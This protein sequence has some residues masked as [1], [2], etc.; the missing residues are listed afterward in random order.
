MKKEIIQGT[1]KTIPPRLLEVLLNEHRVITVGAVLCVGVKSAL[2][3]DTTRRIVKTKGGGRPD[4]LERAMTRRD[5][6]M[7]Q[8]RGRKERSCSGRAHSAL[9]IY[10]N[11]QSVCMCASG[12]R[13]MFF[14]RSLS[15]SLVLISHFFGSIYI[16]PRSDERRLMMM[17]ML[18]G[19]LL[20]SN[21]QK[22]ARV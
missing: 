14:R 17:M 12:G 13:R 5:C 2:E 8:R 20:P 18:I 7:E 9:Y 11:A 19:C 10:I 4:G 6:R 15:L 22:C 16:Y 21:L 1:R 3:K